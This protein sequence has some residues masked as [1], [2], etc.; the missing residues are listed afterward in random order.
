[1]TYV[2]CD[3]LP[4]QAHKIARIFFKRVPV[5]LTLVLSVCMVLQWFYRNRGVYIKSN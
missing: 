4:L 3:I 5:D 1:M 2:K